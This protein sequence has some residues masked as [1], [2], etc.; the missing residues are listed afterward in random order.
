MPELARYEEMD[1]AT[2]V[3][4]LCNTA[5]DG[6]MYYLIFMR[7]HDHLCDEMARY[8]IVDEDVCYDTLMDFFFYLRDG[9]HRDHPMP[10]ASLMLIRDVAKLDG[11]MWRCFRYFLAGRYKREKRSE[12][13]TRMAGMED[14]DTDDE[15]LF[16][17]GELEVAI[18]LLEL[19][20]R[21]FSAPERYIFFSDLYAMKS[22]QSRDAHELAARL[23]CT[24]GNLR[25]MRHRLKAK[26]RSL[27]NES[28]M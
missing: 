21:S 11:W 15:E 7:L 8:G 28:N 10:Y 16:S 14:G 25:V 4:R 20:N 24:Q 12:E 18:R 19:V 1:N 5:D 22:G 13:V 9:E 6:A 17:L 27:L 26:I 2:L 23:G 3:E